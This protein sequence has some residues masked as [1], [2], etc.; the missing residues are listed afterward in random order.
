MPKRAVFTLVEAENPT[1]QYASLEDAILDCLPAIARLIVSG[2]AIR[3]RKQHSQN[4]IPPVPDE[5]TSEG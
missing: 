1:P 3:K 5:P 4:T 2:D